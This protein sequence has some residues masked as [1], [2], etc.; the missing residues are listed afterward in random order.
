ML[1]S[2]RTMMMPNPSWKSS[3]QGIT[4]DSTMKVEYIKTSEAAMEAVLI[5]NYIQKLG[6]VP[7][8]TEPVVIFCDN[9]RA[10]AP[11]K[12]SR[13][14]HRSKYILRLYLSLERWLEEVT[15]RWNESTQQKMQ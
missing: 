6:V 9:N 2:S 7:S 12:E 14:H 11:A 8:I 10:I 3:N 15:F 4:T 13:S 1:A 5:K